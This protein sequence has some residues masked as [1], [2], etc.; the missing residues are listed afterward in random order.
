MEFILLYLKYVQ[1]NSESIDNNF[2]N[3]YLSSFA[4]PFALSVYSS[5]FRPWH[6]SNTYP[7]IFVF[8]L[9]IQ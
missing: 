6:L 5:L 1:I 4:L 8:I 3:N 7:T 9:C 2:L